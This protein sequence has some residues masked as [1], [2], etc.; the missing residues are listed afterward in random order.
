MTLRKMRMWPRA[1]S[2]RTP[3][4]EGVLTTA[5]ALM[6]GTI[7]FDAASGAVAFTP[8][9]RFNGLASFSCTV[10]DGRGQQ[11]KS[12]ADVD[13]MAVNDACAVGAETS[14]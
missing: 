9:A 6:G 13:V 11:D 1:P 2:P 8:D 4:S 7:S 14:L 5:D 10:S 12:M 3:R